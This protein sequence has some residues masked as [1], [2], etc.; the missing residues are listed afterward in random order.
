MNVVWVRYL[1]RFDGL[2]GLSA[3]LL[4]LSTCDWLADIYGLPRSL[5]IFNGLVNLLYGTYSSTLAT[6]RK[7]PIYLINAL[8]LA[9]CFWAVVCFVFIF[10][11]PVTATALAYGQSAFEGLFVGTLGIL[12]WKYRH[13]LTGSSDGVHH[14]S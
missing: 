14:G 6:L 2:A 8:S 4:T 5:V 7:R 3:G 1:L 11:M 13:F 12:E 10:R 9:N